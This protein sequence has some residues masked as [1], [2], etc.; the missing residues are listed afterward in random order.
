MLVSGTAG[1]T[2][3]RYRPSDRDRLRLSTALGSK[4]TM[5][6]V[7]PF[8]PLCPIQQSQY[9]R[10]VTVIERP[11][12]RLVTT[13]GVQRV[14]GYRQSFLATPGPLQRDATPTP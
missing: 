14:H 2:L 10:G 9:C 7:S 11:V 6:A 1:S 13:I 12:S 8:G 3:T 4:S 5:R